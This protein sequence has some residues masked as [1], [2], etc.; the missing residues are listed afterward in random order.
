MC[1]CCVNGIDNDSSGAD[2]T[3]DD[4]GIALS[5]Y[6]CGFQNTELSPAQLVLLN[7]PARAT[8]VAQ[9]SVVRMCIGQTALPPQLPF[10]ATLH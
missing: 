10:L 6:L 4:T 8:R 9:Y 1:A 5:C 7:S 3:P 2:T